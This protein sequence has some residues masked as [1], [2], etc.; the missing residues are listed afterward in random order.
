MAGT[1]YLSITRSY[2]SIVAG[3]DVALRR[4]VGRLVPS[5]P[6]DGPRQIGTGEARGWLRD[7]LFECLGERAAAD[8]LYPLPRRQR[9]NL[10]R[11]DDRRTETLRIQTQSWHALP[12]SS[13]SGH[14]MGLRNGSSL[15]GT[16]RVS[17]QT[18]SPMQILVVKPF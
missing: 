14:E 15:R 12:D 6:G 16:L 5:E 3:E 4:F 9:A 7:E 11:G 10:W 18:V 2:A 13:S 17:L 8:Q 1:M